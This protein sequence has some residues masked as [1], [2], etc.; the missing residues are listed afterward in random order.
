MSI[1]SKLMGFKTISAEEAHKKMEEGGKFILLD[2]RTPGEYQQIRIKGAKLIPVDEI[3]GRAPSELPDKKT[4]I[5]VYCHSGARAG[6]AA[7]TLNQMGY[8]D[9]VS[10][11]GIISWPY[12]TISG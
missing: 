8:T 5:L 10:F 9:V 4:P 7:R 6:T 1:F 11:G 12:Q 2:V 3:S